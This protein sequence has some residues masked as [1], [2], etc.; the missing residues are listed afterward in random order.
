MDTASQFAQII[1]VFIIFVIVMGGGV[2][3]VKFC[4]SARKEV[5]GS[6]V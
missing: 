1:I 5:N 2:A 3:I 4:K 6:R